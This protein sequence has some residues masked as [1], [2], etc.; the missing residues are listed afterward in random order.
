MVWD[1]F[2]RDHQQ[3]NSRCFAEGFK[4]T[5]KHNK[6]HIIEFLHIWC[7]CNY[8]ILYHYNSSCLVSTWQSSV[9]GFMA[10]LDRRITD[11]FFLLRCVNQF[12]I[13][14]FYTNHS[15]QV[16]KHFNPTTFPQRTL[17]N[18]TPCHMFS[19]FMRSPFIFF[20]GTAIV[21]ND[22]K[23]GNQMTKHKH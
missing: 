14:C 17:W 18:F 11:Y 4:L 2:L 20:S 15:L 5:I 22:I 12:T 21:T 7:K 1:G 13:S 19:E 8:Y 6:V 23:P 3:W 16:Q 9:E 10:S